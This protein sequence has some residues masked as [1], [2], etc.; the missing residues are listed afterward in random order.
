MA[1]RRRLRARQVLCSLCKSVCSENGD[2]VQRPSR[3]FPNFNKRNHATTVGREQI[4][5]L[6]RH[7]LVPK[8]RRLN[9]DEIDMHRSH[10]DHPPSPPSEQRPPSRPLKIRLFPSAAQ[11]LMMEYKENRVQKHHPSLSERSPPPPVPVLKISRKKYLK[12]IKGGGGSEAAAASKAARRALRRA[13]RENLQQKHQ[14]D[15]PYRKIYT[16]PGR[17]ASTPIRIKCPPKFS[18]TPFRVATPSNSPTYPN[19]GSSTSANKLPY[20]NRVKLKKVK[21]GIP[22]TSNSSP[23]NQAL[24]DLPLDFTEDFFSDDEDSDSG[25][26]EER[27][28][29]DTSDDN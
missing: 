14:E 18:N 9:P 16:S 26:H 19:D 21:K 10:N 23:K 25:G 11:R 13:K 24:N 12:L 28:S 3:R 4:E 5:K 2:N 7:S 17:F 20:N 8:I 22:T 6:K 29:S 15:N 1:Y 27:R